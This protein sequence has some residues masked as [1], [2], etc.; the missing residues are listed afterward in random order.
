MS[1]AFGAVGSTVE[2]AARCRGC[3]VELST[4]EPLD[5]GFEKA[6]SLIS[7]MLDVNGIHVSSHCSKTT[8][9]KPTLKLFFSTIY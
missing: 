6:A 2:R 8:I 5:G 4:T 9:R 3:W 1:F 7:L